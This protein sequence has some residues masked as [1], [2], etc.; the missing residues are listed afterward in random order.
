[1]LFVISSAERIGANKQY[2]LSLYVKTKTYYFPEYSNY[3]NVLLPALSPAV[4]TN[5]IVSWA[6]K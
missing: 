4:E 5:T 6:K 1:M 2:V 3:T